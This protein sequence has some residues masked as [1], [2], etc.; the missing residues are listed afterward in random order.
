MLTC[1]NFR[2]LSDF[3][4]K[5]PEQYCAI[6]GKNN[7]G[8]T[9]VVRALQVFF[10]RH[11]SPV[12]DDEDI[13]Y[14]SSFPVWKNKRKTASE[15]IELA[16]QIGLTST[17]DPGLTRFVDRIIQANTPAEQYYLSV[18]LRLSKPG[19]QPEVTVNINEK[20]L[21]AFESTEIF[22][23]IRTSSVVFYHNST[24]LDRPM[25][26]HRA[27]RLLPV[28]LAQLGVEDRAE[29]ARAQNAVQRFSKKLAKHNQEELASLLGKLEDKYKVG[30]TF[31]QMDFEDVPM[32]I[33]LA[34]KDSHVSLDDWGSGTRN[35]T[36]VFLVP[37]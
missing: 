1:R 34:E 25:F 29:L 9:T 15:P 30:L 2:T 36:N 6:C 5:F 22:K 28:R 3:Q 27:R 11:H 16:V 31:P 8:K 4:L 35:R 32:E 21:G 26:F 19:N 24:E 13:D 20:A 37:R 18:N 14:Q 10:P 33:T 23:R 12:L 17:A 7:A